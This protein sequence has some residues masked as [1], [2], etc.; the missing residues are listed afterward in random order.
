LVLAI[1]ILFNDLSSR[2]SAI[3]K[4]IGHNVRKFPEFKDT[5]HMW[6]HEELVNGT[7]LT[8]IINETHENIKY[9]PGIRLPENVIAEPCIQK[10]VKEATLLI[11]VLPHQFLTNICQQMKGHISPQARAVSLIKGIHVTPSGLQLFTDLIRHELGIDT[12]VLS[13]AN[14]ASEVAE[15]SFCESTLGNPS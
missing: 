10:A 6:V 8:Q 9:L 14:I 11:F 5:V 3:A 4:I 15:E 13:G 2:G 7:P 12:C 1:G